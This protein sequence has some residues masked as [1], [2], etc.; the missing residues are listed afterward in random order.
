VTGL[1]GEFAFRNVKTSV[2]ASNGD[3]KSSFSDP[4][5]SGNK[6]MPVHRWV[7]WIAGFSSDFVGGAIERYL[8]K[9]GLVLDPFCGVGTTLVEALVKGH[10]SIGFEINPYAALAAKAKL[11]A[12]HVSLSAFK[13]AI[14]RFR[15]FCDK[16]DKADYTAKSFPPPGFRSR[17][18]F[19][20][21][22]VMKKVLLLH[23]YISTLGA[24]EVRD[25]FR[26]AFASTMVRYSNYS[27]E[28]SLGRRVSSGKEDLL[29]FPVVDNV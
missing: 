27:Y 12:G 19:Y 23:D 1:Q 21:P 29:D 14:D 26:L 7:P 5:F 9:P 3:V 17:S 24:A 22:N 4:A 6:I 18:D 8:E 15:S 13:T 10:Q 20:S 16:N 2:A 11:E 28:P 25:L